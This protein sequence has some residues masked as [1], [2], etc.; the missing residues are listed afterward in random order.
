MTPRSNALAPSAF[1]RLTP[2]VRRLARACTRTRS[3]RTRRTRRL[4]GND[5]SKGVVRWALLPGR[6]GGNETRGQSP[7]ALTLPRES[8][9]ARFQPRI[10]DVR[11]E[12]VQSNRRRHEMTHA[13]MLR[14]GL[15]SERRDVLL[16]V[17]SR[18]EKKRTHRH[19]RRSL[20]DAPPERRLDVRGAI[21]MCASSTIGRPVCSLY[22]LTNSVSR[23]FDA[24]LLDPWSTMTTPTV[25]PRPASEDEDP[26]RVTG[27][28]DEREGEFARRDETRARALATERG[29]ETARAAVARLMGSSAEESV[30]ISARR[31]R[32]CRNVV[33]I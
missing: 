25:S 14:C 4:R 20:L 24:C 18:G 8:R 31:Q 3:H 12:R 16:P 19:Q 2:P 22:M 28:R 27:R 30:E 7:R 11:H 6:R 29:G 21:S 26:A 5:V 17:P 9:H 33:L 23:S 32:R 1:P 13:G 10:D 15:R